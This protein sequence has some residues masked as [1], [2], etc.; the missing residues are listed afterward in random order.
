[1]C[2]TGDSVLFV[3]YQFSWNSWVQVNQKI[4]CSRYDKHD[5]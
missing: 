4:A 1:M 2:G 3:V 5:K